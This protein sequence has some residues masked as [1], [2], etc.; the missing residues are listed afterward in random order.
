MTFDATSREHTT[1]RRVRTNTPLQA[2]T[3]LNDEAYF[4]AARALA[5]RVLKETP[6]AGSSSSASDLSASR[7]TYAFRLVAT[8]APKAAELE[9][10][11]ASYQ[12]QLERFRSDSAA[13]AK[14]IKGSEVSGVE[15]AEQ[16][17]WTLVAN[18]LLNLD[19]VLTKE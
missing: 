3:T 10:I 18:A 11:L 8:R 16:A 14:T 2:L 13:A 4:E 15:A 9:R 5:A 7:V 17:A 12:K 6:V 19:E 1:V